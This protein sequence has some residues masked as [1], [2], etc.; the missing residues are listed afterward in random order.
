M[1]LAVATLLA[2]S[3]SAL[4]IGGRT[5]MAATRACNRMRTTSPTMQLAEAEFK[6]GVGS[7]APVQYG[8]TR[9]WAPPAVRSPT[10]EANSEAKIAN[11]TPV[12]DFRHGKGSVALVAYG[13]TQAW[14]GDKEQVA[15]LGWINPADA[16]KFGTGAVVPTRYGGTQAWNNKASE[17]VE[18]ISSC[19]EAKTVQKGNRAQEG[20]EAMKKA[21]SFQIQASPSDEFKYGTGS[22]KTRGSYGGA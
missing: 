7:T 9:A 11:S 17:T 3:A 6:Y 4:V 1:S 14:G 22:T 18:M 12:D 8:G 13:G 19:P 5:D 21:N 16:F 2:S 10:P 20:E 15:K